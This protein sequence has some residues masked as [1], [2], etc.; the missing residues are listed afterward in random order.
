MRK[1]NRRTK[2]LGVLIAHLGFAGLF[3]SASPVRLSNADAP[4]VATIAPA[5]KIE[6]ETAKADKPKNAAANTASQAAKTN[7]A[8][9]T[10]ASHDGKV[11]VPGSKQ[12]VEL[13]CGNCHEVTKEKPEPTK[14]P[15]EDPTRKQTTAP[16]KQHSACVT[17]HRAQFFSGA[18]ASAGPPICTVCHVKAGPTAKELKPFPNPNQEFSQFGDE[19]SHKTHAGYFKLYASNNAPS[20][21]APG[22][23]TER[24]RFVYASI[25]TVQPKT[26][27]DCA[28]CH[29][30]EKEGVTE[31]AAAH[32]ACFVCHF[33]ESKVDKKSDTYALN[34][35]GCH[36]K[37]PA[38]GKGTPS[39]HEY[40]RVEVIP[41]SKNPAFSHKTHE[42]EMKD[43]QGAAF[44][45]K[46][47]VTGLTATT[48]ADL[49]YSEK[50]KLNQP[51][52]SACID[53]HASDGK[54]PRPTVKPENVK[55]LKC[56]TLAK[57]QPISF[58][59][60]PSH[61]GDSA[62]AD[63]PAEKPADKP[64]TPDK[65]AT[66]PADAPATKTPDPVV[67]KPEEKA[68]TAP[69]KTE[70]PPAKTDNTP[71]KPSTPVVPGNT[72]AGGS[73]EMPKGTLLLGNPP[74]FAAIKKPAV[75]FSHENH[76]KPAY[77]ER[78]ET[79]HHTNKN[80]A[81]DPTEKAAKCTTCHKDMDDD[82]GVKS[83]SGD[84]IDFQ[85]AYHGDKKGKSNAG[86]TVCHDR[87]KQKNAASKAP[88]GC[89]D[90]HTGKVASL[91]MQSDEKRFVGFNL[92]SIKS[93]ECRI[94]NSS[95][96]EGS[97]GAISF[98]N[99]LCGLIDVAGAML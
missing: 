51:P 11:T 29:S 41:E 84:I 86:C 3:Y 52:F 69:P 87:A 49:L 81:G 18:S 37:L 50:T 45:L 30:P 24:F 95:P 44:C 36:S 62:P 1:T 85:I 73:R 76:T 66:K 55:C 97:G 28:K 54:K 70:N 12:T 8:K 42:G 60:P 77:A 35:V 38:D 92:N 32:Q 64:T 48:R 99:G 68:V 53:C 21:T 82:A 27:F 39:I 16:G 46:C 90:C 6:S 43:V 83:A 96:P 67:K 7:Y 88:T 80:L 19:F 72:T 78:C 75:P 89:N 65:S 2:I 9:F 34:C 79:C 40:K 23:R 5:A 93:C 13:K 22:D 10:H 15:V 4:L 59:P 20:P 98:L 58:A 47:H 91:F 31:S 26:K 17:C 56:H 25:S 61:T 33:D 94:T 63:K 14:F 74:F 71:T 57:V